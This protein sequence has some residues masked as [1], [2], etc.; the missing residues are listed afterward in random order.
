MIHSIQPH[1]ACLQVGIGSG[2]VTFA[3]RTMTTGG[4]SLQFKVTGGS[5]FPGNV[6]DDTTYPR[7]GPLVAVLPSGGASTTFNIGL[8]IEVP[9]PS[10]APAPGTYTSNFTGR[11]MRLY[12]TDST[13][14]TTCAALIAGTRRTT[15]GTMNV[16]ATIA[17]QCS[18]SATPMNFGTTGNLAALRDTTATVA[19]LC[20][21]STPVNVL[22]DNGLYGTGP[23]TRQMGVSTRRVTYG[24]YRDVARTQ[25]WGATIGTNTAAATVTSVTNFTAYGRVPAQTTPGSGTYTDVVLIT[26]NY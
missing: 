14:P 12:Y 26:V 18:V 21:A 3:N 11:S 7:I 4:N 24:I 10:A 15:S 13:T 25:P 2:G 9:A 23:T 6:G 17:R 20:N 16:R 5:A 22:M 8:A 1:G 19:V